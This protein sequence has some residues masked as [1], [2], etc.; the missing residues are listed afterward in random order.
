MTVDRT[1][2]PIPP[3]RDP[4]YQGKPTYQRAARSES[5]AWV[6]DGHMLCR[7][8][9]MHDGYREVPAG[10]SAITSLVPGPH[11]VILGATSGARSH[12]LVYYTSPP[13]CGVADM[14]V[15][16]ESSEVRDSLVSW[17]DH[18]VYA[19]TSTGRLVR[20]EIAE[21][22]MPEQVQH[23]G[24][25]PARSIAA[26]AEPVPGEGI[27]ALVG[28]P[29]V[30]VLVGLT[31]PSG[32]L[33]TYR[34]DTG[35]TVQ[36]GPVDEIGIFS[37]KLLLVGRA[38][39]GARALG[40]VYRYDA[41]EPRGIEDLGIAIPHMPGRSYYSQV[42]SWTHDSAA[43]AVYGGDKDGLL[44]C[45]DLASGRMRIL[46]KPV[47]APGMRAIAVSTDGR[48]YGMGGDAGGL[49]HLFYWDPAAHE[50]RDLGLP[51]ATIERRWYGYEFDAACAGPQG[52][53]YFGESERVSHLFIYLPP[54]RGR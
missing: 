4:R 12:L 22:W 16:A 5:D 14:G 8:L 18:T 7:R 24:V 52:E 9:R 3:S 46:G 15:L 40:R 32:I 6:T 36:L 10:E 33:F 1:D 26:V 28:L 41:Y 20:A 42:D 37:R 44:F 47:A 11:G 49:A 13:I 19:G 38:V 50:L 27:C 31:A 29:D 17:D 39:Y 34:P 51:L 54:L 25:P 53:I 21:Y 35:E 48:V 43:G 2:W 30:G 23:R 45:W